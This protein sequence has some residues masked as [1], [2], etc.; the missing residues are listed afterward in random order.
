MNTDQTEDLLPTRRSLLT[1][2]KHWD[3]Q[4]SWREFFETYWELIFKVARR[5][6]LNENQAQEVVQNTIIDVAK[7]LPGFRYDPQR[8]S[9]KGW[10]LTI[11]RR[12][13][14]DFRRKQYR[15]PEKLSLDPSGGTSMENLLEKERLDA[16]EVDAAWETEWREQLLRMAVERLKKEVSAEHFQIFEMHALRGIPARTVAGA[17]KV[18][19]MSVYTVR[20]RLAARLRKLVGEIETEIGRS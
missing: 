20:H 11:A 14:C 16:P 4:D 10:L 15:E 5:A 3:D 6:G 8:G 9:F 13:I 7:E 2:L 12:R 19:W 1:R 18:S 17:L